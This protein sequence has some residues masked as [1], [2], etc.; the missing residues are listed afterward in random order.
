[1]KQAY[2]TVHNEFLEALLKLPD[3][4]SVETVVANGKTGPPNTFIV[5]LE[6]DGLPEPKDG[7]ISQ[8]VTI[9]YETNYEDLVPNV[10]LKEIKKV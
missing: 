5:C 8:H 3:N 6:G 2:I 4:I 1:M 10:R 9:Q 7:E